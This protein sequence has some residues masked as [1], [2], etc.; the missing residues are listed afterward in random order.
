MERNTRN[1][2]GLGAVLATFGA[3][4]VVLSFLLGWTEAARPWSFVIG[5]VVG[6]ACGLGGTL[7][8]AGLIERRRD[9]SI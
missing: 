3:L 8:V 2:L 6:I 4:G 1:R 7:S 9:R 5:F